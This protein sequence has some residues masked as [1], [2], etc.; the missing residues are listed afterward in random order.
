[1]ADGWAFGCCGCGDLEVEAGVEDM[2][3]NAVFVFDLF[4]HGVDNCL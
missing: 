1:M 4:R 3:E 2:A